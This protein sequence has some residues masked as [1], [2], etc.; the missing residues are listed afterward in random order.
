MRAVIVAVGLWLS[1]GASANEAYHWLL[2]DSFQVQATDSLL[3]INFKKSAAGAAE[4]KF[5]R[6]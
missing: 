5:S 1:T 3:S 2:P 4:L 6:R